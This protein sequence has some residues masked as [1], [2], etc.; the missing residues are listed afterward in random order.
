MSVQISSL[1]FTDAEYEQDMRQQIYEKAKAEYEASRTSVA[2]VTTS[3]GSIYK[4]T[5]RAAPVT[6]P[7]AVPQQ[8]VATV[9]YEPEPATTVVGYGTPA[10]APPLVRAAL[11]QKA[12]IPWKTVG[13]VA[14]VVAAG[15]L[16]TWMLVKA[17]RGF[18]RPVM[19]GFAGYRRRRR[20]R[21]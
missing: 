20:R 16:V 12:G 1:G 15:G 14:G 17:S 6:T 18:R 5:S 9:K 21:R 7:A 2:P 3:S 19:A 4:T 11:A 8:I 13:I 10:A